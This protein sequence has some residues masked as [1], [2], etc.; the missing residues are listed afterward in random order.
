MGRRQN[1]QRWAQNVA[2]WSE[3]FEGA[4]ELVRVEDVHFIEPAERI[5]PMR[6]RNA[7]PLLEVVLHRSDDYVLEGFRGYLRELG[8]NL[9]LDQRISV[10]DL[11]FLPVRVPLGQHE[12]MARFSFLRV[13]REMPEL[14]QL[15]PIAW[16]GGLRSATPFGLEMPDVAPLNPEL[17]VSL[18]SRTSRNVRMVPALRGPGIMKASL[19]QR[20][21]GS[22]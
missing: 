21:A 1:F 5:K 4:G 14:R 12:A 16:P 18:A 17:R 13:A 2:G 7:N 20:L 10:R 22:C 6:T 11:C 8:V 9:D 15:R 19:I 3:G